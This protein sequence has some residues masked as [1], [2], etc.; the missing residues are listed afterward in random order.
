MK[1]L[2]LAFFLMAFIP[3]SFSAPVIKS[4]SKEVKKEIVKTFEN[5]NTIS[6]FKEV[7]L[8]SNKIAKSIVQRK[9]RLCVNIEKHVVIR[10]KSFCYKT[11]HRK[12]SKNRFN[13]I[14]EY[15]TEKHNVSG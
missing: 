9:F 3:V 8:A 15:N 13:I 10:D 5:V 4:A 1:K 12:Y 11:L 2:I 14:T 6:V 7:S